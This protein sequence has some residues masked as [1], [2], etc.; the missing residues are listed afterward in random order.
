MA[1][2]NEYFDNLSSLGK[3]KGNLGDFA[4]A[5]ATFLR[6]NHRLAPKFKFLFHVNFSINPQ[7][8]AQYNL[9]DYL[10]TTEFNLL[11]ESAQ[12][13]NFTLDTETLNMYNRKKIVQTRINYEPVE[14][15]FHDDMAGLTTLLW[16]AYFRYYYQDGEYTRL[17]SDGSSNN[18][19]A[20][21]RNTPVR[22]IPASF[23]YRYGLDKGN[24]TPS[25][26]FFNSITINQLHTIDTKRK[27][28]SIT[29]LNPMIQTFNHD[30]VEYGANDFMKN[31]MRVQYESVIY[32]RNNTREDTPS[33]FANIAHY[34]K[35]PSPL[36]NVTPSNGLDLT[37]SVIFNNESVDTNFF[38][39]NNRFQ[40]T[41]RLGLPNI[42]SILSDPEGN[43]LINE[44]LSSL[45]FGVTNNSFPTTG[46]NAGTVNADVY[47]NTLIENSN[48]NRAQR[49][50]QLLSNQQ[51]LDDTSF[52]TVYRDELLQNGFS[53]DF[54]SQKAEWD[55]LS[56]SAKNV[57]NQKVL[58]AL[59]V[60]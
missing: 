24:K 30:R 17:N 37:W 29:L 22:N 53:G 36:G 25:V 42:E 39:L 55:S 9:Q 40:I 18:N 7:A 50:V 41:D 51:L 43:S 10:K 38:F 8:L 49:Y 59:W 5:S 48:A 45:V 28:T 11:V 57:Y 6:N 23:N 31:T 1:W 52:A 26:P 4:H 54:N 32:G 20:A 44:I 56:R 34:D 19:P 46:G 21:F 16:E 33:G 47:R 58:N 2:Q 27:H 13:P 12:L 3:V 35:Q 14:I 60:E 15:V